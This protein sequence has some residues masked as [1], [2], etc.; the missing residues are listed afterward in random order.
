MIARWC[1]AFAVA[2]LT[3]CTSLSDWQDVAGPVP[4]HAQS[5]HWGAGVFVTPTTILTAKH[6]VNDCTAVRV[7]S[8]NGVLRG[9]PA[10]VRATDWF[11]M[12]LIELAA[13]APAVRPALFR[14]LWPSGREMS[15]LSENVPSVTIA[16]TGP[17]LG[18][19]YP[20]K[21]RDLQPVVTPVHE[22]RANR[23]ESTQGY[24][25]LI[26]FGRVVHGDSGGPLVDQDGAVIGMMFETVLTDRLRRQMPWTSSFKEAQ[27]G[28]GFAVGASD[29]LSFMSKAGIS[30][31]LLGPEHAVSATARATESLARVFCY[32]AK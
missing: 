15:G 9:V 25:L 12:A 7:A 5:L 27:D 8:A 32:R 28:V 18:L 17:I 11:D 22:L 19:G 2:L 10:T 24:H 3:G 6:V 26:V 21:V 4:P 16:N 1:P 30:P 23:T 13:S 20:D 31:I 14:V 29:A